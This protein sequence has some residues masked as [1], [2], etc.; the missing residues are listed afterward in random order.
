MAKPYRRYRHGPA[1]FKVDL[2]IEGDVPW[3]DPDCGR[4]G[5]VHLGGAFEEIIETERAI[6]RGRLPER[7]FTL[8]GQQYLADPSRSAGRINPLWVYAHVRTASPAT[9][10]NRS[11]ARSS[12]SHPASAS[13]SSTAVRPTARLAAC[14]PNYVRGDILTGANLGLQLVA[15][16]RFAFDSYDTGMPGT[17]ICSAASPPG[18]GA[19]GMR[20]PRCRFRCGGYGSSRSSHLWI[21]LIR[22]RPEHRSAHID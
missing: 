4:A 11:S 17:F 22:W 20:L 16:P 14:N 1:A 21:A 7:P 10:P 5:T 2:A 19:H 12:A 13:T 9:P 6:S 15:R 8:V 3:I 18:A